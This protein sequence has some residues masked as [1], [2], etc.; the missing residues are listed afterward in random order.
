MKRSILVHSTTPLWSFFWLQMKVAEKLGKTNKR[1]DLCTSAKLL[2]IGSGASRRT[3]GFLWSNWKSKHGGITDMFF[4]HMMFSSVRICSR[5]TNHMSRTTQQSRG[6]IIG[7]SCCA[8]LPGETNGLGRS[9][10]THFAQ[11]QFNIKFNFCVFVGMNMN[12]FR[13]TDHDATSLERLKHFDDR[14]WEHRGQ[15]RP[16]LSGILGCDDLHKGRVVIH[17]TCKK[18][19]LE[20]ISDGNVNM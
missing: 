3:L 20:S 11:V 19:T 15:L 16:S 2:Y 18:H 1:T 9:T 8:T 12:Q 17:S 14:H 6:L 4:H 13:D 7:W 10:M 5:N